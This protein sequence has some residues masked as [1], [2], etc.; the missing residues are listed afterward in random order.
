MGRAR[1][2]SPKASVTSKEYNPADRALSMI[3]PNLRGLGHHQNVFNFSPF[4]ERSLAPMGK[5]DRSPWVTNPKRRR[6]MTSFQAHECFRLASSGACAA[7]RLTRCLDQD[8]S[9]PAQLT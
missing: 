6:K 5:S 8:E 2:A 1:P 9:A 4:A 3:L 7:G